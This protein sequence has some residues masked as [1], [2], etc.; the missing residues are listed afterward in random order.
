[1]IQNSF[2]FKK[3]VQALNFFAKKEGGV[4]NL[5]KAVK[6]VWLSDRL[7]LR[8]YGRSITNDKYVAMKNGPV[9]SSTKDIIYKSPFFEGE[10]IQYT[11][12][13]LSDVKDYSFT[14]LNHTDES[15]FSKTDLRIMDK[16]YEQHGQKNQFEL[17][18][19][20][21]LFPEWR[22]FERQ[23]SSGTGRV[24][25]VEIDDFFKEDNA[26]DPLFIQD[27]ELLELSKEE[28]LGVA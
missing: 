14:S 19:Y 6:L 1:M 4:I 23:L 12:E 17:S 26:N 18:D 25:E 27:Q 24:F 21:H 16:V 3:A 28:Y 20:S 9:P 11:D 10:V 22:R 13:Y 15:V 7:H 5:M 8:M 2:K